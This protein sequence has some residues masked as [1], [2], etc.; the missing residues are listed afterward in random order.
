MMMMMMMMMIVIL[1]SDLFL[2]GNRFTSQFRET[3]NRFKITYDW[4]YGLVGGIL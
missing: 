4:L 3:Q 1:I 2:E